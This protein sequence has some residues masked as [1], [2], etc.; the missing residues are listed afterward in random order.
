LAIIGMDFGTTNSGLAVYEDGRVRLLPM[1][2]AN[3]AAPHVV[4]TTLYISRSHEHT[5]GRKAVDEYYERNHGRP[6]KLRREY[7]GTIQLTF[8]DLGTFYR[9]VFVWVDELEP[10][11]LFRSL[12]TFLPDADYD[13][14]SIW[15]RFYR[16][17]DLVGTF[18][19]LT[20]LRA[21]ELL[22]READE[23][24]LG[25]PVRFATPA[26]AGDPAGADG[27]RL[28]EERLARAAV[29]AGYRRVHFQLEPVA[30]AYRYYQEREA[31]GTILVFDFGGGTLDVT[32]ME[33][34]RAGRRR[35]PSTAGVPIAGDVFDRKIVT[36]RLAR[37][38]GANLTYGPKGLRIPRNVFDELSDWHALG[39]MNRPEFLHYLAEVERTTRQPGQVRALRSLVGNNYGLRM[40]DQVEKAKIALSSVEQTAV[41]L[42]GRDLA[43]EEPLGRE[44]FEHTIRAEA[45]AV[46]ACV[47]EALRLAQLAPAQV[48]AV[49]RTGGSSLIPLFQR[50]LAD[51]FGAGKLQAIDEF[52]SVT[53]GLAIASHLVARGELE[54]PAYGPDILE[55][56]SLVAR[57]QGGESPVPSLAEELR[58]EKAGGASAPGVP[59]PP[60]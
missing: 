17:E 42:K 56:G 39:Q 13:G 37:H 22:G 4:R 11:R 12:K 40:F 46:G 9:D 8:A 53:A 20:R 19:L 26:G 7:V 15:G 45:V 60:A 10:G 24:V 5:A 50:M 33:Q 21:E 18:L 16:L 47:D 2:A 31:R 34:D 43:V 29:L 41:R 44:Q 30:A 25:R 38:F 23:V 14:T 51:K 52:S 35:V 59:P 28:A 54:L 55:H 1:D 58:R 48:D 3:L 57:A 32:G 27:D 36:E 6:V 49:I